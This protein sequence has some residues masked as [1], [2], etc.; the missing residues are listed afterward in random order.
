MCSNVFIDRALLIL[1]LLVFP[2]MGFAQTE[3][4]EDAL[5]LTAEELTGYTRLVEQITGEIKLAK[6]IEARALKK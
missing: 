6:G 4:D 3:L 1:C 5:N 2:L